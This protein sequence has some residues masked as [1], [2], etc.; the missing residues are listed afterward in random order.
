MGPLVYLSG[1]NDG[2]T[3]GQERTSHTFK[4]EGTFKAKDT[5]KTAS[6]SKEKA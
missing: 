4:A 1:D 2:E 3:R 6:L 5:L